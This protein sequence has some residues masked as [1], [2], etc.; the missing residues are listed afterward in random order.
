MR[1]SSPSWPACPALDPDLRLPIGISFYTFHS[2]SYTIDLYRRSIPPA[3]SLLDYACFVSLFPHLV[4]GPIL[5]AGDP[6]AA[7][8][9]A[10][11]VRARGRPSAASSS[12]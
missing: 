4:A 7:D 12:A 1:V 3:R 6:V 5:R 8:R 11:A 9:P 10:A 2:L